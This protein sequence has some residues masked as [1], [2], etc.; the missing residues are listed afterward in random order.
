MTVTRQRGVRQVRGPF[1]RL[2]AH[3]DH[4]ET[5]A[6]LADLCASIRRQDTATVLA[7][8]RFASGDRRSWATSTYMLVPL[9]EGRDS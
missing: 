5:E 4:C 7:G 1:L 8:R 6:D 2:E 9:R 3:R